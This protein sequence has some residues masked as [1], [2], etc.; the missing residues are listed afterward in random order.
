MRLKL[1]K[2]DG[3]VDALDFL[4][5]VERNARRLQ[6]NGRQTIILVEMSIEHQYSHTLGVTQDRHN[7]SENAKGL[8]MDLELVRPAQGLGHFA[9][10]CPRQMPQGSM[11]NV[12]QPSYHQQRTAHQAASRY[13]Q[14]G[15]TF[16]GQ[17]GCGYGNRG[18]RDGGGR[19]TGKTSQAGGSQARI[20]A[21]NPQEAQA[22]NA[23]VQGLDLLVDLS[24]LE[25]LVFDVILGM[26]WLAQHYAN[27]DFPKKTGDK[28]KSSMNIVSAIKAY[29]KLR[30]GCQGFLAIVQDVKKKH[31]ELSD[32]SVVSEYPDL[33]PEELPGL[34][35]DREIELC[36]ISS[37]SPWGAPV[38]FM[39]N[40]RWIAPTL[41]GYHKL[42]IRDDDIWKTAFRTRYR[43]YEFLVMSFRLTNAPTAFM[44]LMNGVFK[45]F[46][47][48]FVIVFMDNIMIYSCTEEEHAHH[49]RLVLQTLREHQLYAKF[50]KCEIWLTKVAFLGHVVSQSGIKVDPK[51]IEAVMKWKYPNSV[52]EVQSSLSLAG[53]YR[54]F[55]QDFSK[56]VVPLKKLT[57]KNAR[58][59]W[60][61]Q[62]EVNFLKLKECL[63]TAPVLAVQ[64]G[65]K[66]FTVY[67]DGS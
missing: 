18:G 56:I 24:L 25:V 46:L 19:G 34:P 23:F 3:S 9:R 13:D 63:T 58:F 41:S 1:T 67:C 32:V 11:T 26:D 55:V 60:T 8:D 42:K 44:D 2:F 59:N 37:V 35:R 4:E 40:E 6:A 52:T 47:D 39:K 50:S 14:T 16:N 54:R 12:V 61:D 22:S 48:Q 66:G 29:R 38:L 57:R 27:V 31:V 43:H 62:C 30:K 65:T 33:F 49:L 5:E 64:Q 45:P 7:V 28:T 10:D 15:S 51:K 36:I 20:F 21:L 17:I 53:Y